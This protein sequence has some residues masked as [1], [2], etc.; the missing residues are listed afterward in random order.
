MYLRQLFTIQP[1]RLWNDIP[2]ELHAIFFYLHHRH[3]QSQ[4][5]ILIRL[6][7]GGDLAPNFGGTKK[8]IRDPISGKISIFRVNIS[9]DPF[10]SLRP[11]SSDFPFLFPH[12]PYVYYV[13][14]RTC[15]W[16]F[17]HKKNTIFHS[18]HTF[19][20]T[21]Q[22][23]FSKY[24]GTNAWAVPRPQILGGPSPQSP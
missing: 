6:L 7:M 12:F 3:C 24:W 16:P 18:V 11:G 23:C 5:I 13:K 8:F 9:D 21:R 14:C 20:H 22:N 17:P 4:D 1:T 10:F 15:I 19:M 2:P